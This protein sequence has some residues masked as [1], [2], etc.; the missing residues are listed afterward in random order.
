[1]AAIAV[2][3]LAG[4]PAFETLVEK[5]RGEVYEETPRPEERARF[6]TLARLLLSGTVAR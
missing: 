1:M 4:A 2:A 6:D 3:Y 5:Y